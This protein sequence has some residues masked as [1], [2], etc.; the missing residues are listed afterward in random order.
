MKILSEGG[1]SVRKAEGYKR[2]QQTK[3]L[4]LAGTILT[5]ASSSL[6]YMNLFL[7]MTAGIPEDGSIF[8]HS[9]WLN[10]LV[11]GINLDSVLN[12]FGMLLV[13]GVLKKVSLASM[14]SKASALRYKI[15][16]GPKCAPAPPATPVF[17]S[18][19][20]DDDVG[21]K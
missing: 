21:G 9:P 19:A 20:Y 1:R 13:S 15:R 4:T 8:W 17:D 18:R 6:L 5:V 7:P 3:R 14:S 10:A 16:K 2:L 12:D 11:F